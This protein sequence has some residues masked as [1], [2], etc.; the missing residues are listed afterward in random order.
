MR[1]T[2]LA[3]ILLIA[4]CSCAHLG[5]NFAASISQI[6]L[7]LPNLRYTLGNGDYI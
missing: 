2:A 7:K 4:A 5:N 3:L 6:S 1:K